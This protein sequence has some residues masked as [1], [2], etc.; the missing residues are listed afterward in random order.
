MFSKRT[1]L[2]T[3]FNYL[4]FFKIIKSFFLRKKN[5]QEELQNYLGTKNISLTSLGRTA[6]YEIIKL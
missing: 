1:R 5:F 4:N 2:Y 3:N 6:L